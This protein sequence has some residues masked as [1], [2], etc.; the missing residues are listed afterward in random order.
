LGNRT[1]FADGCYNA[2]RL[3][4]TI[5]DHRIERTPLWMCAP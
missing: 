2:R 3:R 1:I 4:I 5:A